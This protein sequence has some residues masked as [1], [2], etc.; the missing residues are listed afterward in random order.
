M[1]GIAGFWGPPRRALLEE[2]AAAQE[3]RGPDDVGYLEVAEAS[4]AVRRLSIID[5]AGG[6]QPMATADGLLHLVYNGEL[7]TFRELRAELEALGR[8]FRTACDTEVVLHAYAEWGPRCFTR[9]NG[10]WGLALLDRRGDQPRLV[11]ARDHFGIKPVYYARSGDRLLFASEIKAILRDRSFPRRVDE[12]RLYEYLGH[13]LFDHTDSTFFEG[14]RRLPAASYAVLDADGM[15][16]ERYWRP[17]LAEDAPADPATFRALF[18]RAVARRLV[19]D[20]PVGVC[21]SGGLDSSSICVVMAGQ[22][23]DHL[24]DA[25]ALGDRLRTFSAVFPGDPID[26]APYI[27]SV[28]A[29]TG[30][31]STTI[32]PTSGDFV[33]ELETWTRLVEEPTVS[34]APFAMWA[35]MGI[36]R[37]QVKVLLDGQGGDELLAGYDHYPYVYLRQLLRQ[38]RVAELVVE[39]FRFRDIVLPLVRRR[40]GSRRRRLDVGRLLDPAFQRRCRRPRDE[41]VQDDLKL[42]LLQD[43]TTYSLPP[44]LRYEDR[45]SMA[46][47]IETRLPFLDQELVEHVLRLPAGAI[48]GRGRNRVILREALRGVL[49][50]LVYRR[51]RKVGFITPEFRWFRREQ[52]TLQDILA[53]PSFRDRGYWNGPAVADAFRRA[54]EG[55]LEESRFFWRAVNAE[56][57]MRAFMDG[58]QDPG[59]DEAGRGQAV[60][61][62]EE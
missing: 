18:E 16:L 37:R 46:H 41:R 5:I 6:H 8:T 55:S 2:M 4:L 35:V 10:M 59:G 28:L 45:L 22:L 19:A 50:D 32:A 58:R 29:A 31:R 43:F 56:L 30:A 3:H 48:V 53:S 14:V 26:E 47:S 21:L 9:F 36:A 61:A 44:L 42:R 54:C 52:T 13:G 33:R 49:P 34:S 57:W 39:A 51:R 1:C 25:A 23:R 7:H 27:D 15:R 24:P 12:Q 60:R 11:L 40:L 38:R 20:V 62:P 17:V